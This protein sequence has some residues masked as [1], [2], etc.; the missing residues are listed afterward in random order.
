MGDHVRSVAVLHHLLGFPDF[1]VVVAFHFILL[2][3]FQPV[4]SQLSPVVSTGTAV[5][6]HRRSGLATLP[7]V[8]AIP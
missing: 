3:N 7:S 4:Y 2:W 6:P 8:G 5:E 1:F